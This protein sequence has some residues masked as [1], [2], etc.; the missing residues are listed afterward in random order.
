MFIWYQIYEDTVKNAPDD[1]QMVRGP[2]PW[3]DNS[4]YDAMIDQVKEKNKD[5]KPIYSP[6]DRKRAYGL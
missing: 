5:K 3:E 2:R 4:E 6:A 1:Y